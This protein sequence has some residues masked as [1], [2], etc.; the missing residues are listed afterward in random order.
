MPTESHKSA[1]AGLLLLACTLS[2]GR[3][4]EL[5]ELRATTIE[6]APAAQIDAAQATLAQLRDA[7]AQCD[8]ARLYALLPDWE[9]QVLPALAFDAL[10]A[11]DD[12]L[13]AGMGVQQAALSAYGRA[14][15]ALRAQLIRDGGATIAPV[16]TLTGWCEANTGFIQALYGDLASTDWQ[17]LRQDEL[18]LLSGCAAEPVGD[19]R[20]SLLWLDGRWRFALLE[21][22]ETLLPEALTGPDAGLRETL[23]AQRKSFLDQYPELPPAPRPADPVGRE[24]LLTLDSPP[25]LDRYA[26]LIEQRLALPPCR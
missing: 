14:A 16:Q 8:G 9:L 2:A 1:L 25:E 17:W 19:G 10:H 15:I 18:Q 24:R 13:V 23:L 22:V 20:L 4:Q 5:Q 3:A 11:G 26:S 21:S 12:G 7:L 6:V